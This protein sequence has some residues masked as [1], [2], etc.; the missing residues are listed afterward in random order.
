MPVQGMLPPYGPEC[1]ELVGILNFTGIDDNVPIPLVDRLTKTQPFSCFNQNWLLRD[2]KQLE[3]SGLFKTVKYSVT[4]PPTYRQ[5]SVTI[6]DKPLRVQGV[7][8]HCYGDSDGT[9]R[10]SVDTFKVRAGSIYSRARAAADANFLKQVYAK[11]GEVTDVFEDEELLPGS[12]LHVTY[13]V[14]EYETTQFLVDGR[15]IMTSG[16]SESQKFEPMT[17]TPDS[18]EHSTETNNLNHRHVTAQSDIVGGGPFFACIDAYPTRIDGSPFPHYAAAGT[19]RNP[20]Y[21]W[22]F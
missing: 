3:K 16:T 4:G 7:S 20:H 11:P 12:R 17:A 6:V 22:A 15:K 21:D 2:Q 10:Q 13:N 18:K 19:T 8:V 14:L 9:A 5:I 1:Q